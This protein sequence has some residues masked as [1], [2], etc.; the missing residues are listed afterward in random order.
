MRPIEAGSDEQLWAR[1]RAGDSASF[2]TVFDRHVDAVY[3]HC[4]R[5]TGSWSDADDLTS[6]AFFEVW[7][8]AGRA[9][10]ID[11]SLRPWLLAVATNLARTQRR[12]RRRYEAMLARL[13][14]ELA[15]DG[16]DEILGSLRQNN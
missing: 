11:G 4:L 1:A 8:K 2:A 6:M 14:Q 15:A 13:A 10:F 16:A 7:R 12:A 5:R 9:R 3:S